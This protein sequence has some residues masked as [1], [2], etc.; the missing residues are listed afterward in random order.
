MRPPLC[1]CGAPSK[2][3]NGNCNKCQSLINRNYNRE[4]STLQTARPKGSFDTAKRIVDLI[5]SCPGALERWRL[6]FNSECKL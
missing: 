3:A 5:M 4:H 1:A 2:Y 6:L